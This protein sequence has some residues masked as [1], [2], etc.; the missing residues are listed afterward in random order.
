MSADFVCLRWADVCETKLA[1]ARRGRVLAIVFPAACG[2]ATGPVTTECMGHDEP[3]PPVS[4]HNEVPRIRCALLGSAYAALHWRV[5]RDINNCCSI[6]QNLVGT[7]IG[8]DW[9]FEACFYSQNTRRVAR[10][11][12]EHSSTCYTRPTRLD[13]QWKR[14][15]RVFTLRISGAPPESSFPLKARRPNSGWTLLYAFHAWNLSDALMGNEKGYSVFLPSE[16]Q[17]RRPKVPFRSRRVALTVG[18]TSR[19]FYTRKSVW[20]PIIPLMW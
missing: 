18:N 10:T 8:T 12:R 13:R 6:V 5:W 20:R 1:R 2:R 16:D 7:S 15:Q 14:L 4:C 9:K 17:A 19:T 3:Q 11:V